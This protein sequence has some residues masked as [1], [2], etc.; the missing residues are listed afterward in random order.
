MLRWA[1]PPAAVALL[2]GFLVTGSAEAKELDSL[3][4]AWQSEPGQA[5]DL[6]IELRADGTGLVV[7]GDGETYPIAWSADFDTS[8]IQVELMVDGSLRR[9]ILEFL[10][11][12][13]I[14][15]TEPRSD[16]P[17]GFE[18]ANP[19]VFARTDRSPTAGPAQ[20]PTSDFI[21][22]TWGEAENDVCSADER[23]RFFANG[24][25]VL[26]EADDR[27]GDA[28][29]FWSLENSELSLEMVDTDEPHGGAEEQSA[30]IVAWGQSHMNLMLGPE[31]VRIVR[32]D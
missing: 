16:Y 21:V 23:A 15:V 2:A 12:D 22:G 6:L 7:E 28:V 5:E 11:D 19:I 17:A 18:D 1:L 30:V 10:D 13:R 27:L 24:I 9:S 31:Q 29:G 14:R 8:P 3:V 26:L 20:P 4:G 25:V 32:C